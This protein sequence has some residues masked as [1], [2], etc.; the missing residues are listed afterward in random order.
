MVNHESVQSSQN[1][2]RLQHDPFKKNTV[3]FSQATIE[4]F[5][6]EFG[7][8]PIDQVTPEHIPTFLNRFTEGNKPYT[9]RVRYSQLLSIF[10]FVR[11]NINP[12]VRNP[13]YTLMIRKLYR[14]RVPARWDIIEKETGDEII[15]G[16]TKQL[17]S[18][19][20][21]SSIY[22]MLNMIRKA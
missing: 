13:C 1:L 5:I 9:K 12:D 16:T 19:H 17:S 7:N 22:Y 21:N 20:V 6:Q 14:E 3:R 10:D 11:N 18:I 2:D 4:R 8:G 15:L